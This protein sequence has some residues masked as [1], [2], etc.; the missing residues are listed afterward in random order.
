MSYD[1]AGRVAW[2]DDLTDDAHP[3][4]YDL[5]WDHADALAV[6]LGWSRVDRRSDAPAGDP[7]APPAS[8]GP[9]GV[10]QADPVRTVARPTFARIAV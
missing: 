1:Y 8:G 7:P 4:G 10:V 9:T 2:V 5:C 6:P 3:H